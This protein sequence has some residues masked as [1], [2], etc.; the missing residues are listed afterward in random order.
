MD[1]W[2]VGTRRTT[3]PRGIVLWRSIHERTINHYQCGRVLAYE[4]E[5]TLCGNYTYIGLERF[6]IGNVTGKIDNLAHFNHLVENNRL[7]WLIEPCID[8]NH[9]REYEGHNNIATR[10]TSP[11][12]WLTTM[13]YLSIENN[14]TQQWFTWVSKNTH[15]IYT[16][17]DCFPEIG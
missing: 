11:K 1:Y 7:I 14:P 16:K 8:F 15:I 3:G 10:P 6:V 12:R 9:W 2:I 13:I 5:R 17:M 4:T